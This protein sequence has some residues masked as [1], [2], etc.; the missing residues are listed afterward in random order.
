MNTWFK[1]GLW[2][3]MGLLSALGL[4]GL[5]L[6]VVSA[7]SLWVVHTKKRLAKQL[8]EKEDETPIPTRWEGTS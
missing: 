6:W 8:Q 7:V 2:L 1:I 3:G 5:V 4:A